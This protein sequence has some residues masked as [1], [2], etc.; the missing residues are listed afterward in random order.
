MCRECLA[1]FGRLG[2]GK[3]ERSSRLTT[4][5]VSTT[6]GSSLALET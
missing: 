1:P 2:E 5:A 3:L 4:E 6:K